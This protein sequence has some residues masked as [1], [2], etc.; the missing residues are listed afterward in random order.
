MN[1][2]ND[3]YTFYL[4]TPS[5]FH[6]S[7]PEF[8]HRDNLP[9]RTGFSSLYAV[10]KESAQAI[11]SARTTKG[12][13]GVVWSPELKMDFDT[14]ESG[15]RA[16]SKLKEMGYGY[17]IYDTGGRGVHFTIP[18]F[19]QHPSHVLPRLQNGFVGENFPEAD[20]SIYTHLHLF[21]L[22]GT[23]HERTG[24]IKQS[25]GEYAGKILDLRDYT[26]RDESRREGKTQEKTEV[27]VF[28]CNRVMFNSHPVD[29]GDRHRAL[30][31][32]CYALKEEAGANKEFALMWM[33]QVNLSYS[34]PKEQHEVEKIIGSIYE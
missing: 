4:I 27:S 18:V 2:N 12:F 26:P 30:V 28:S 21:R 15:R 33:N 3:K 14:Y 6:T 11:V 29:S 25:I 7:T 22:E 10:T 9:S 34:E 20:K 13:K 1:D 5:H 8:V 32:L 24:G 31:K 23:V 19:G 16:E 17:T